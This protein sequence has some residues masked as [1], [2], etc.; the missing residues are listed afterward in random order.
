MT[1]FKYHISGNFRVVTFSCFIVSCHNRGLGYTHE[2]CFTETSLTH[3]RKKYEGFAARLTR[4]YP[5]PWEA[6]V[7]MNS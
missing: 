7:G 3:R 4:V 2:N 1:F 5:E 6:A